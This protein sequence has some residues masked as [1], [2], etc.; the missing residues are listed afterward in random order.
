M[1]EKMPKFSDVNFSHNIYFYHYFCLVLPAI[2]N[3]EA[4]CMLV[5]IGWY[6]LYETKPLLHYSIA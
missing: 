6:P 5:Y 4:Y 1:L 2:T 3:G